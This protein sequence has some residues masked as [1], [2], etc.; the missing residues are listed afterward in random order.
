MASAEL[1][2][3]GDKFREAIS[4]ER[5]NTGPMETPANAVM[6]HPTANEGMSQMHKWKEI[7][8]IL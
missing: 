5:G 6:V 7:A 3:A 4:K 8:V 2:I 1:V